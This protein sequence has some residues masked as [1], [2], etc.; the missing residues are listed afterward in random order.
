MAFD[1]IITSSVMN[2]LNQKS[3]FAASEA[4]TYSV[5]MVESAMMGC[6]KLFHLIVSSLQTNT[7]PD[8]DFL[9]LGSD[10]KSELV[11]PL[12]RN[13]KSPPKIRTNL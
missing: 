13:S 1:V 11:Y 2:F 6:L 3:S 9:S 10:M 7:Y 8:I 12:T 4:A 5:S